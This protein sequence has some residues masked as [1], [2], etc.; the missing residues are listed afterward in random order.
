MGEL[1]KAGQ[2]EALTVG[3]T[4]GLHILELSLLAL[5]GHKDADTLVSEL[6][7]SDNAFLRRE[8]NAARSLLTP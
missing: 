2:N 4:V 8:G 6:E 3:Q 7:Q 1:E 5:M